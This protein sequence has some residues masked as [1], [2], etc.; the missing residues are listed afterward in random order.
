MAGVRAYGERIAGKPLSLVDSTGF[1]WESVSA[2]LSR[3]AEER[4]TRDV[5]DP[6]QLFRTDNRNL[7]KLM[8]ILLSVPELRENL[9]AAT[10]GRGPDGDLLARIVRSWVNGASLPEM[11]DEYFSMDRGG[12]RVE[13]T[14]ALTDCCKNVFGRLAQTASWGL[15]AL[16][17]LN[18]GDAFNN[19][20]E[21]EQQTLR[22]LPARVFYGVNTNE[23]IV[24]RLLGVPRGAAQ[25][26]AQTL[27]D[28]LQQVALSQVRTLLSQADVSIWSQAMGERGH[29]YFKVWKILEGLV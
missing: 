26:L 17:T 14:K 18:I 2:T 27:G 25:P 4:I 28:S 16:Q 24:L 5:W 20:P 11:A 9:T 22:N 19:L 1:S 10:G 29:V 6:D 12:N 13:P 15:A 23:A 7:Q 21:N 3:L 8:G